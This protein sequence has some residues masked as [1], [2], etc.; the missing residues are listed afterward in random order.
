[1]FV[2]VFH[3]AE[4]IFGD[5]VGGSLAPGEG[6]EACRLHV[7]EECRGRASAVKA[8]QDPALVTDRL[9]QMGQQPGKYALMVRLFHAPGV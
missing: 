5:V 4:L 1:V 2:H 7:G 3:G 6:I 9:A 8:D